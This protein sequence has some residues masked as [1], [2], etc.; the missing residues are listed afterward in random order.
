MAAADSAA[1]IGL[2]DRG[3]GEGRDGR[4]GSGRGG[5]DK[6]EDLRPTALAAYQGRRARKGRKVEGFPR[7]MRVEAA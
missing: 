4:S 1:E 6:Q 5:K 2:G 7:P 3:D